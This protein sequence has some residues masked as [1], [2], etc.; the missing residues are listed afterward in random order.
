M[1]S[2]RL[3][4]RSGEPFAAE[5]LHAHHGADHAAVHVDVAHPRLAYHAVDEALDAAVDAHSEA[6]ARISDPL[7]DLPKILLPVA[8][9]MEDRAEHL[10]FRQLLHGE[11]EGHG[12]HVVSGSGDI[13]F[14]DEPGTGFQPLYVR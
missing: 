3:G 4:P 8:A 5:G 6:V 9:D 13:G 10:D 7:H 14:A 2:A 12:C 11:L 1:R